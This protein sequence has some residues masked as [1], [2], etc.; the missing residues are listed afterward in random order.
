MKY[1]VR[2]GDR[3][4]D[5]EID[6]VAPDYALS[7][8]GR[9]IRI[10]AQRLGV[11]SLL[12]VLLNNDSY[13]AHVV[14]T[15]ERHGQF[16]VSIAGK[17]ARLQVLD[18]LS[19]LAEQLHV[20]K[21]NDSYVLV[22]PMPGLVVDV[23]VAPGD[24]VDVGTPLVV[25]EAMKMQNELVSEVAGTVREVRATAAQPVDSGA[26]LVAIEADATQ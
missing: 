12:S 15:D 3:S 14:P 9:A 2:M 24:R 4:F 25:V 10:D 23:F 20:E 21:A 18:P 5:V 13:L 26:L 6:G 8:D 22:A 17:V 19:V 16:D 7:I 11:E 1:Q